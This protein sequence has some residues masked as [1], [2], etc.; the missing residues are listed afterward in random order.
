VAILSYPELGWQAGAIVEHPVTYPYIP[1]LLS[2]R[3]VPVLLAAI[4]RLQVLPDLFLCD[5]HG[6]AHPR[7]FG[8]ACHLGVRLD[9]PTIG[10][11]KTLLSGHHA[12]L[13]TARGATALLQEKGQTLGAVVR[14]RENVRPVYVSIGHRVTLQDAIA[15]SLGCSPRY[16]LPEPL[17]IAHTMAKSGHLPVSWEKGA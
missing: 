15:V 8:L 10:C 12:R 13:G 14:T 1:G 5:G 17:R 3:E 9:H 4:E 7:R 11:A 6:L 16:R 2:F